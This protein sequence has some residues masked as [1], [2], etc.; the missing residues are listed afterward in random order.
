ML[1]ICFGNKHLN[2]L[3]AKIYNFNFTMSMKLRSCIFLN[4]TIED[5]LRSTKVI[6]FRALFCKANTSR[7][8][9]LYVLHMHITE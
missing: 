2:A 8:I 1:C 4:K 5:D 7:T 9:L 6:I 3:N